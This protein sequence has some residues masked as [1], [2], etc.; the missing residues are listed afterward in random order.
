V[1]GCW[2]LGETDGCVDVVANGCLF[3]ANVKVPFETLDRALH[4]R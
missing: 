1:R 2:K 3:R 4:G